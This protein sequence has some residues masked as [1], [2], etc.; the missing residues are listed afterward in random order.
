MQISELFVKV[1]LKSHRLPR[2]QRSF[3]HFPALLTF[4]STFHIAMYHHELHTD[5]LVH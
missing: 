4:Y 5:L 3:S 1:Y 2:F